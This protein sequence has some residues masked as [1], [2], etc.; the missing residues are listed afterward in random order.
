VSLTPYFLNAALHAVL[1]SAAATATLPIVRKPSR[2]AVLALTS[3]IG[4]GVLPWISAM[5]PSRD[6]DVRDEVTVQPAITLPTWR[7]VTLPAQVS[8]AGEPT[9][10]AGAPALPAP[11]GWT[12][13]AWVWLGGSVLALGMLAGATIRLSRWRASLATPDSSE[14]ALLLDVLP[15]GLT[16]AD[17]R[18]S[19]VLCSPCVAGSLKPVLILPEGLLASIGSRELGWILRHEQGHLAGRDSRWTLLM[20]LVR[21]VFWWNPFLHYL[22]RQWAGAR[23]EVCDLQ[24]GAADRAVY[25]N[26]L[27]QM[28][29][30]FPD[31]RALAAPMAS[32]AKRRLH[33]RIVSLLNAPEI[34][35]LRA[36]RSFAAGAALMLTGLG[37][38]TS[39]VRIGDNE[40]EV[41]PAASVQPPLAAADGGVRQGNE[42]HL[43]VTL[44]NKVMCMVMPPTF[45]NGTVLSPQELQMFMVTAARTRGN[46]LT[47]F[48][49]VT[50]RNTE[51]GLIE[52]I[53]EK[54]PFGQEQV[55]AGWQLRQMPRYDGTS[56]RLNNQI[57]YAFVPGKQFSPSSSKN[58]SEEP[59]LSKADW[60]KLVVKTG[61]SEVVVPEN[62]A[63]VTTLGEVIPGLYSILITEV[64]PIDAT[65]RVV[66]RYRDGIYSTKARELVHGSVR[67]S[68]V[69]MKAEHLSELDPGLKHDPDFLGTFIAGFFTR[70]QWQGLKKKLRGE[71]LAA[72]TIPT[73]K[74]I[75]PWKEFEGLELEATRYKD[76]PQVS[77][78]LSLIG[79]RG[80]RSERLVRQSLNL[81]AGTTVIY[82][83]PAVDAEEPPRYVALTVDEIK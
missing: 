29:A 14:A 7:I 21:A 46:M 80:S 79:P 57:R 12:L 15:S 81:D 20:A 3:V 9:M 23:E 83:I 10:E 22:N 44:S 68:A 37:L 59:P 31:S 4:A 65:G 76:V 35:D 71:P 6:A 13:A 16:V 64:K 56:L 36:G 32:G 27:I 82:R 25:G 70:E 53:R 26:F 43:Q 34:I 49:S 42:P 50:I 38:C 28:A 62:H 73:G 41:S 24:A 48:P 11:P 54:A 69:Q 1:L 66:R 61:S 2:R 40:R 78:D 63:V 67:L 77:L 17:I 55:T 33:K 60:A 30:A 74:A 39:C 72:A 58:N 8:V 47:T 75:R 19:R 51:S 45:R 5:I 18:L 52:M